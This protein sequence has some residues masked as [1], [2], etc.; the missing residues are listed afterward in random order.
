MKK[1]IISLLCT[2]IFMLT[3]CKSNKQQPKVAKKHKT[4]ILKKTVLIDPKQAASHPS[5]AS[6][7]PTIT[8]WVHGSTTMKPLSSYVHGCPDGL[9]KIM[10]L[11]RKYRLRSFVKDLSKVYPARF[12]ADHFYAFGWAGELDFALRE[13]EAR[14]LYA[15]LQKLVAA[16]RAQ[17]GVDPVIRLITHSHG[18]NVV[19]NLA[20][21]RDPRDSFKVEAI[22]LACPIQKATS[23]LAADPFFTKVYSF[24]STLDM[25][26]IVDPQ[27]MY[28]MEGNE[29]R[30]L[31]LSERRLPWSANMRQA[32]LTIN[33]HGLMHLAFITR[34]FV[35]LLPMIVDAVE[36]W[37][38]Q[39]PSSA[40]G[41]HQERVLAIRTAPF[42]RI[43]TFFNAAGSKA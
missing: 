11:P 37:E 22:I 30:Q 10:D 35:R 40:K 32:R 2:G 21:V 34:S 31:Q 13:R 18:G 36:Q 23:G 28:I 5:D 33:G 41:H 43:A 19:L 29:K 4:E 42:N 12:P 15:Q 6:A 8:V 27:G 17:H 16:Y 25:I 39:T 26:Q 14:A 7:L 9:H 1:R 20:K 24:Y 3:G 38:A